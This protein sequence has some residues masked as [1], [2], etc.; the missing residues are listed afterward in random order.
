MVSAAADGPWTVEANDVSCIVM[1][2][3]RPHVVG[4]FVNVYNEGTLR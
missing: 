3:R 4:P 1:M 2:H